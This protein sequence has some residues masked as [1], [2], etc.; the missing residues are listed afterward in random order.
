[1]IRIF[2]G[3]IAM[4]PFSADEALQH[5]EVVTRSGERVVL[6]GKYSHITEPQTLLS[7][8]LWAERPEGGIY[9]PTR[10][11]LDGTDVQGRKEFDLVG[12]GVA[13]KG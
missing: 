4:K 2:S 8:M 12:V 5:K 9:G 3:H 10:W 11:H 1:M 7:G 13:G 6:W